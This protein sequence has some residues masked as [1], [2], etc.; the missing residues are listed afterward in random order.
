MVMNNKNIIHP[1]DTSRG[2]SCYRNRKEKV[3]LKKPMTR[4][5]EHGKC[6]PPAVGLDLLQSVTSPFDFLVS[7]ANECTRKEKEVTVPLLSVSLLNTYSGL[8]SYFPM[9]V[10]YIHIC[11]QWQHHRSAF[12]CKAF[13]TDWGSV[14]WP[15]HWYSELL[16][17]P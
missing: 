7:L 14:P 6:S 10:Q 4:H 12:Q 5:P 2:P 9:Y 1:K 13:M 16:H 11:W 3:G 8:E 15:V 17:P